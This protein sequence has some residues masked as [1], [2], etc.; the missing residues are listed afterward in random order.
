MFNAVLFL[1]ATKEI[2]LEVK[3]GKIKYT[4]MT[5][6]PISKYIICKY[7]IHH[8]RMFRNVGTRKIAGPSKEA[9]VGS[10]D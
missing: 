7:V 6:N 4:N 8:F 9:A 5:P 10:S 3:T 1:N 2:R